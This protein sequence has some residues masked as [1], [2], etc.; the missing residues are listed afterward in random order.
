MHAMA[1]NNCRGRRA[2]AQTFPAAPFNCFISND[3]GM[4]QHTAPT[5]KTVIDCF[6]APFS[7]PVSVSIMNNGSNALSNIT[8]KYS[9]DGATPVSELYAGPIAPAAT[10]THNFATPMNFPTPGNHVIKVWVEHPNDAT[11]GNDTLTWIKQVVQPPIYF[12]PFSQDFE[13]FNLCDT[14]A[15]CGQEVCTLPDGWTNEK[16][17]VDDDID[18]RVN[19]GPTPTQDQDA[20]T[21]PTQDFKPGTP[22]G[23]YLYLEADN[24]FTKQANLVSP[25][26]N[27]ISV[28]NAKMKFAYHMFGAGMGEM[29]VDV[30]NGNWVTDVVPPVIG[31]QGNS[32]KTLEVP[33]FGFA[34]KLINIR[35]R[36]ITGGTYQ[37]DI[38]L[39]DIS[40]INLTGVPEDGNGLTAHL[41]PNPSEG[42]FNLDLINVDGPLEISITSANGQLVQRRSIVPDNGRV[43]TKLDLGDAASGVYFLTLK[44][45]NGTVNRKLT[46]L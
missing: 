15:N 21:G 28:L 14:A 34:G 5:E 46:K 38:A 29:H 39:D 2:Y 4:T 8:F 18:W 16:N 37:S 30:F 24:C 32:W 19:F 1:A 25:C 42:V 36:G 26:I 45:N 27:L 11:H 20:T 7:E 43:S 9:L 31:D 40:F 35:F 3:I 44:S 6:G 13:T 23:Q 12:L 10:Y 41:Y 33:L 22:T 17:A